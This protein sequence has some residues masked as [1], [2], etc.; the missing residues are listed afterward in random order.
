MAQNGGTRPATTNL[1]PT[2]NLMPVISRC[3]NTRIEHDNE[4]SITLTE[5]YAT[6]CNSPGGVGAVNVRD[7]LKPF[8][9]YTNEDRELLVQIPGVAEAT[10]PLPTFMTLWIVKTDADKKEQHEAE[11]VG[12]AQP[13]CGSLLMGPLHRISSTSDALVPIPDC[14]KNA[15]CLKISFPLHWWTDRQLQAITDQPH[16]IPKTN[17]SNARLTVVD[18]PKAAHILGSDDIDVFTPG[19]WRQALINQ[20]HAFKHICVLLVPGNPMSR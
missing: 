7:N 11:R 15:L 12:A 10:D 5:A 19:F 18:V 3:A 14:Y 17:I 1:T 8:F 6:A 4:V 16:S 20:L 9:S 13:I 2:G